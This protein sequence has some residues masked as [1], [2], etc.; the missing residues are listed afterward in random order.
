MSSQKKSIHRMALNF[1]PTGEVLYRRTPSLGLLR[2][3]DA[4]EAAKLIEQIHAGVCG[5]HMNGLTFARKVFRAG[6]F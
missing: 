4:V 2:Y 5:T 3:V 1:I 6:Y